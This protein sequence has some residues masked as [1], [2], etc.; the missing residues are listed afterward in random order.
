MRYQFRVGSALLGGV[1]EDAGHVV[2]QT[3]ELSRPRNA[4]PASQGQTAC[5]VIAER[6]A[7]SSAC[8]R[9]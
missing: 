5:A 1:G 8:L 6:S 2:K 3:L 9:A 7:R 4:G